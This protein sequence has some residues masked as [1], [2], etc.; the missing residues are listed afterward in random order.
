LPLIHCII[1]RNLSSY[2]LIL[3]QKVPPAASTLLVS[4]SSNQFDIFFCWVI[5]SSMI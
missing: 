1:V 2:S 3:K 5:H 4:V